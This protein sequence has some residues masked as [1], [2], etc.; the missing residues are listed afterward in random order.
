MIQSV[1]VSESGTF[2]TVTLP[3]GTTQLAAAGFIS[4]PMASRMLAG[5]NSTNASPRMR[6]FF[7][8]TIPGYRSGLSSCD[9]RS[10]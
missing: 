3:P 8:M 9:R 5:P 10:T 6:S 2:A 7:A 1:T 4:T